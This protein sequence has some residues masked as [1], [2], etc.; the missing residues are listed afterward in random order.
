M[1]GQLDGCRL[2]AF[3]VI[4]NGTMEGTLSYTLKFRKPPRPARGCWHAKHPGAGLQASCLQ[5]QFQIPTRPPQACPRS[6]TRLQDPQVAGLRA[7]GPMAA[8]A[9]NPPS[10]FQTAG[11][12]ASRLLPWRHQT[13]KGR[14]Q[15]WLPIPEPSAKHEGRQ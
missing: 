7:S 10:L 3:P 12:Q 8:L 9:S 14:R 6:A 13:L 5:L 4:D 11:I 15:R 1:R 2:I